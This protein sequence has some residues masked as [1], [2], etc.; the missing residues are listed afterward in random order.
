MYLFVYVFV[1][2][3]YLFIF[4]KNCAGGNIYGGAAAQTEKFASKSEIA[5]HLLTEPLIKK[6]FKM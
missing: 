2:F 1:L 5:S 3:V 4:L 6:K